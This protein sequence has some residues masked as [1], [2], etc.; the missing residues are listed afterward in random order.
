MIRKL[1]YCLSITIILVFSPNYIISNVLTDFWGEGASNFRYSKTAKD[2]TRS[3]SSIAFELDYRLHQAGDFSIKFNSDSAQSPRYIGVVADSYRKVWEVDEDYK[4]HFRV[5]FSNQQNNSKCFIITKRDSILLKDLRQ[6]NAGRWYEIAL[7]IKEFEGA[8]DANTEINTI[9]ACGIYSASP[10]S[11]QVWFDDIYFTNNNKIVGVTE[12][13]ISNRI[14][15]AETSR[16]IR[17]KYEFKQWEAKE[18][19][20]G[21]KQYLV[22]LYL[23]HDIGDVNDG[24]YSLLTTKD[25]K[26][27][28]EKGLSD[29]WG[30]GT[31]QILYRLYYMF[32]SEG[33]VAPGRLSEKTESALLE[34]LWNRTKLKNDIY[35]ARKSTWWLVGSENHDMVANVSNLLS[36]QI[37]MNEQKFAD[38][39]Y[40]D[41]GKGS[42]KGYW[43]YHMYGGA[44]DSGPSGRANWKQKGE[45]YNARDHYE[46]WVAFMKE[47]LR[48]RIKRGFFLEVASPGYMR[49]TLSHL[50][51]LYDYCNDRELQNLVEKFLDVAWTK[52]SQDAISGI[53]GGAKTRA[54]YLRYNDAMRRFACFEFGGQ[55]GGL[56]GNYWIPL[57]TNYRIP[58]YVW[59]F[60]LD[61][62]YM[63]SY[64]YISRKPGEEQDIRPRPKGLERSMLCDTESRLLRYSWVTPDYILGCQMDHPSAVHSHLSVASRWQGITFAGDDGA[65]VFPTEINKGS[66]NN[67]TIGKH[68]YFRSLQDSNVMICQQKRRW[69]QANPIWYPAIKKHRIPVGVYFSENID[70]IEVEKNWIFVRENNAYLAVRKVKGEIDEDYRSWT[71]REELLENSYNWNE[72]QTMIRCDRKFNTF[73]FEAGR[74][75][76]YSNINEFKQS[77]FDNEIKLQRTVV[78]GWYVV[79]YKTGPNNQKAYYFNAANNE[80]PKVNGGYIDYSPEVVFKSPYLNSDYQSG[81]VSISTGEEKLDLEFE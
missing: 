75:E 51:D 63:G 6:F 44:A 3:K 79:I 18:Q 67:W 23:G 70:K 14:S 16:E 60:A 49:V 43:F 57:V 1:T 34:E 32:G 65:R 42:G 25:Q 36:S 15:L 11:D 31:N 33:R 76:N 20:K 68:A 45:Q 2:F 19:E 80:I 71:R 26:I 77:I 24:L 38:R 17:A 78:P 46:A 30:L 62:D 58:E 27:R 12:N 5:R 48:Q 8:S 50:Y 53:R 73:I 47:Y 74:E 61:R 37:F 81:T 10:A 22:K 4:L 41:P 55:V 35:L 59:K 39:I 28:F 72:E 21:L 9:K 64:E 54:D 52:W 13:T 66:D 29:H 40:P 69:T 7:R 56:A